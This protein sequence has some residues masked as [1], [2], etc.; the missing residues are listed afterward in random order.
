M[1]SELY[2]VNVMGSGVICDGSGRSGEKIEAS[3]API[4]ASLPFERSEKNEIP[5]ER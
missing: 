3:M 5:D 2:T 4:W 1:H